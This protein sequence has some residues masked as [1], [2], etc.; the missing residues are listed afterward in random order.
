M[1]PKKLLFVPIQNPESMFLQHRLHIAPLVP[2]ALLALPVLIITVALQAAHP[3]VDRILE[4]DF[5]AENSY[6]IS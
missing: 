3:P 5:L 1:E 2:L 4:G 6:N